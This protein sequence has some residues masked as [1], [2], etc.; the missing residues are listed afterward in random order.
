MAT[1]QDFYD[2]LKPFLGL[3]YIWGADGP[4]AFDCSGFAQMALASLGLD[5][6]GDQS[7]DGLYR[8]FSDRRNGTP[9]LSRADVHCGTIVFYGTQRRVGHIAICLN[10]TLMIEAGGGGSET[11]SVAIA[12]ATG[13]KVRVRRID[14]RHDIVGFRR[15]TGLP[16]A[17][18]A[19]DP[20]LPPGIETQ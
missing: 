2:H 15:P 5:P 12:R 7:A 14:R 10:P 19:V 3:P 11:I 20:E 1:P 18:N 4:S 13:A 17:N 16:W 9:V 6:S 8:H